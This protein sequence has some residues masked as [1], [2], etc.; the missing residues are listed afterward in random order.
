MKQIGFSKKVKDLVKYQARLASKAK[1]D[2]MVCS[3]LEVKLVKNLEKEIITPAY[4]LK[5]IRW[6][7]KNNEPKKAL[8]M[9]VTG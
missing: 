8:K 7:K 4:D 1:L 5:K 2:A 6:P 3:P 9:E